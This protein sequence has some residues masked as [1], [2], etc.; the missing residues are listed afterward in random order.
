MNLLKPK[1]LRYVVLGLISALVVTF[2]PRKEKPQGHPRDYAEIEESGILHAA[3]EYNSIS[4][5]VDG[6]TVSGFHYELIEAFARDKGLQVQVSPVM[7]FN[8][9]LEGLANGTYDVVAYGIPTTSE[10]KDSLL[11]TSPIILSKQVLVQRKAEENDSL[12][13]RSQLDLAGKT[14]NVVKG[15]PS[16]LRIHNLS[17]EI[18]DTIYVN[19]VA[20]Y[21]SEQLIAMVAHGDIDF[22]VCD[23]SIARMAADSLPQLDINT[24]ISF[25]QFYSWG[26]SKQSPALLDSLNTWLSGF[27][28]KGE[29]QAI[30]RKY[31][32]KQ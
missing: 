31:Y 19:E 10:L 2:W 16:I 26:V 25:T 4:F 7:S 17:N 3:T 11:L 21:G 22:A 20:K 32:G 13:I 24:A 14:L 23:E 28:K 9:R 6:D 1:Y 12:A 15:S 5:Y 18:G 27:R 29:Y 30:Y 8:Q